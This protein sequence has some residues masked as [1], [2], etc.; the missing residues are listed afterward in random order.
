LPR[1]A[2]RA[3][4][5]CDW[6]APEWRD[7][8]ALEIA[9][10]H[11]RSSA[12]RPR[13]QAR[14]AWDTAALHAVFRVEDRFVRCVHLDY[15]S[16]VYRDSCVELFVEPAAGRGYFNFEL[17][18]GGGLLLSHIQD[19]RRTPAGFARFAPVGAELGGRVGIATSLAGPIDP[20]RAGPLTW[21]AALRIPFALFESLVGAGA[22]RA[23][24]A[25][26]GNLFKCADD[27]SQPHWASWAPIGERLDFHQPAC[28]GELV[29]RGR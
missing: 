15:Q 25:W 16:P 3:H 5:S 9:S 28:F 18:C 7:V 26:R 12:H 14:L 22:P 23:G 2:E 24:E 13:T 11:P 6:D 4:A 27:S 8:P 20:E 10:F 17:S 29:F 21:T 19:P 1:R